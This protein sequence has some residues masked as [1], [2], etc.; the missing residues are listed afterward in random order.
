MK[1]LIITKN[2]LKRVIK[3]SVICL[4]AHICFICFLRA[5]YMTP[6]SGEDISRFILFGFAV[7][8]LLMVQYLLN[9]VCTTLKRM[10]SPYN[11]QYRPTNNY[12]SSNR[13]VSSRK[14]AYAIKN[15]EA[16]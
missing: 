15:S 13:A 14:R 2:I 8:T 16:A 9:F 5:A 12:L 10:R 7:L 3:L 6:L 1:I 4:V 11:N